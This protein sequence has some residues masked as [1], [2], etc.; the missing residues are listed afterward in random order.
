MGSF[1]I[2]NFYTQN[3]PQHIVTY[4]A[5][6]YSEADLTDEAKD[7][8]DGGDEDDQHVVKGQDGSGNQ[9]V[10]CPAELSAAKQ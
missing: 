6:K 3:L 5:W 9:Q 7:V 2:F 4:R 1:T 10:A 8:S